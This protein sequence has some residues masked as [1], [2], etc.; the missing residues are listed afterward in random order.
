MLVIHLRT[1]FYSERLHP[2]QNRIWNFHIFVVASHRNTKYD[3]VGAALVTTT[4]INQYSGMQQ[5]KQYASGVKCA[6]VISNEIK[7]TFLGSAIDGNSSGA[8]IQTTT[9]PVAV[10]AVCVLKRFNFTIVS[11]EESRWC[12]EIAWYH[13]ETRIFVLVP[14][15]DHF[16]WH[17]WHVLFGNVQKVYL[18]FVV[19]EWLTAFSQRWIHSF[20][21][22]LF[23]LSHPPLCD[24]SDAGC[25]TMTFH[26]K[27]HFGTS[28]CTLVLFH[29]LFG[30]PPALN[31]IQCPYRVCQRLS[32]SIPDETHTNSIQQQ[33]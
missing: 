4:N 5:M 30:Q 31:K 8:Q 17:R 25:A 14:V 32:T 3:K 23:N 6:Q 9:T 15:N 26:G 13:V 24:I 12:I 1:F 18:C 33:Q 27:L 10:S 16:I 7:S 20:S 22:L 21:H 29:L 19:L 28:T 11:F 2:F